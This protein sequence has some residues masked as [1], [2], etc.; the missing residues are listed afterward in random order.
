MLCVWCII[1][2]AW[3]NYVGGEVVLQA[4]CGEINREVT[5]WEDN[6]VLVYEWQCRCEKAI[7]QHK[8]VSAKTRMSDG[9]TWNG[10]GSEC[11]FLPYLLIV[12]CY[13]VKW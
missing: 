7:L 2:C 6:S 3:Y 1:F 10:S 9:T 12:G 5:S 4:I 11:I 8:Q 13:S